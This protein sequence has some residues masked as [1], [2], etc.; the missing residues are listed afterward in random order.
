MALDPRDPYDRTTTTD[1]TGTTYDSTTVPHHRRGST[2][3]WGIGA[4][5][6]ILGLI[7]LFSWGGDGDVPTTASTTNRPA[8][9]STAPATPTTPP[10]STTAPA[11]PTAPK[12]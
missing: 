6:V 1:R 12:Q 3:G 10:A 8:A 11:S 4:L 5:I 2:W 9:T 7:A